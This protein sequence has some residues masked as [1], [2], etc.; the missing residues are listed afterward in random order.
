MIKDRIEKI[1]VEK[2]EPL[3]LVINEP[4]EKTAVSELIDADEL[5]MFVLNYC[6]PPDGFGELVRYRNE[7]DLAAGKK[8]R[9]QG[10]VLIDLSRWINSEDSDY[11]DAFL[12][13][14]YDNG[15]G[16]RYI[17]AVDNPECD[18]LTGKLGEYFCIKKRSINLC[19]GEYMKAH[20]GEYF[21]KNEYKIN[22]KAL[23]CLCAAFEEYS[24]QK[25]IRLREL[26]IL[27]DKLIIN[28]RGIEVDEGTVT[29][30]IKNEI[31]IKMNTEPGGISF[32]IQLGLGERM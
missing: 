25:N 13:Y 12:A 5:F 8:N 20:I 15:E 17:F 23:S 2:T 26:E 32:G 4:P 6:E 9:Y 31:T 14:L 21:R 27:C 3:M 28:S 22:A 7:L 29:E 16:V 19:V 11:L 30:L 10:Y 18:L 1:N 24:S